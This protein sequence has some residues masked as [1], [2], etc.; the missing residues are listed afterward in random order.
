[1]KRAVV[2]APLCLLCSGT[3]AFSHPQQGGGHS[4]PC[5]TLA[6]NLG[7]P[8]VFHVKILPLVPNSCA[9]VTLKSPGA[10][11]ARLRQGRFQPICR[12]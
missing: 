7:L 9:N 11:G 8:N 6:Q 5:C 3:G 4:S 2:P 12:N 10:V 1:M